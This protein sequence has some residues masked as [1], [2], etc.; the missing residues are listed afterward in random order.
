VSH[1]LGLVLAVGMLASHFR[2]LPHTSGNLQYGLRI[3]WGS[4]H[5]ACG[6]SVQWCYGS[7]REV[8]QVGC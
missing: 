4:K 8:L 6:S 1:T 3:A 7:W 2:C 5:S